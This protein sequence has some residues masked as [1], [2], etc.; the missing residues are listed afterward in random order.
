MTSSSSQSRLI[1][2]L[3]SRTKGAKASAPNGSQ[4]TRFTLPAI[5]GARP[6]PRF[7]LPEEP[8]HLKEK[9]DGATPAPPEAHTM[10]PGKGCYISNPVHFGFM[11]ALGVGLAWLASYLLLNVGPLAGWITGALFIGL[12][13]DPAVRKFE[14][15]GLPRGAGVAVVFLFFLGLA[16]AFIFWVIP[17]IAS[18]AISFITGF[19]Q[20]FENFLNSDFFSGLDERYHIRST[21]DAE[22][23]NFFN[24]L[25]SDSSVVSTFLNSLMNAGTALAEITSGTIIVLF[26]S[27]YMLASLPTIKAWFIRLAPASRRE[28]VGYLTEKITDSVGQ[29]VMGQALVAICNATCAAIIMLIVGVPFAQLLML[30][31]L[32]LAFIPLIGGVTAAALVSIVSLL[33]SWQTALFFLIPYLIYLQIEAY[34]ISPRIMSRAV[35]VPGAVAIIAVAA[36]GALWGVLGALIGIPVAAALLILV[37]EVLVPRQDQL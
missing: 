26:L 10:A 36:G 37:N 7:Q 29:Y 12:G 18:Q 31:V 6:R 25:T 28:R 17:M 21:V 19:P 23:E 14:Q 32:I 27:I 35:A 16:T 8:A 5:P 13:L 4:A 20:Q 2:S 24:Q 15:L 34:F 30:F 3:V 11:L 9:K 22:V 1:R 33:D